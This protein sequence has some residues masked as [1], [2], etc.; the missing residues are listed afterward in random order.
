MVG[1]NLIF[2]FFAELGRLTALFLRLLLLWPCIVSSAGCELNIETR[3]LFSYFLWMVFVFSIESP[4]CNE[5]SSSASSGI[6]SFTSSRSM[7][8]LPFDSNSLSFVSFISWNVVFVSSLL[9]PLLLCVVPNGI[10]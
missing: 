10:N 1:S 4:P 7:L 3:A 8:Y 9:L 2:L 6:G 5:G